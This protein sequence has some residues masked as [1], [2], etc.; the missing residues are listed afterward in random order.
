MTK[1]TNEKPERAHIACKSTKGVGC[2]PNFLVNFDNDQDAHNPINWRLRKKVYTS[3][4][5]SLTSLGSVWA[6][7]A[8]APANQSI[9]DEFHT[10][11]TVALLGTCLLLAGWAFGPLLWAPLSELYGRKWPVLVPFFI[12]AVMSFATGAAKD[13]QTILITRF[14]NGFFGSAPI[15]STGA[16]FVDLWTPTQRGMAIVGYTFCVCGVPVTGIFQA[17]VLALDLLFVEESY[18]PVLLTRKAQALRKSTGNWALHA[19]WEE[20]EIMVK[21][22][23]IKYGLRPLQMLAT[24][25]CLCI[26]IYTAFIYAIYYASLASFPIIFQQTRHWN[27]LTGS[28]PYLALLLGVIWGVL[29]NVLSQKYYD[30]ACK[31]N[32]FKAVPEARLPQMMIGSVV[33]AASLFII[34]CTSTP[35]IHWIAPV[36][37]VVLMG[38]GYYAVFT[39]AINYLVDTFPRWGASALAA[40]TVA[41]S[42]LAAALPLAIQ[43]M[44]A[45]L[46]NG[47]AYSVLGFFATLNILIPY[48]FYFFGPS[49]RSRGKYSSNVG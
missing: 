30:A 5:Y 8:Y 41:R 28:L 27:N 23:A 43:P 14:F 32:D 4:L 33:L 48:V 37:G 19:K 1:P 11:P 21:D 45:A 13:I 9:A 46:G 40:N 34:G 49:I 38:F 47:W 25:I 29:L 36:I 26:T 2:E 12:S 22:L 42:A 20:K 31:A 3:L 15:M 44:F 24:P 17:L 35:T 6:S 18:V 16:V 7:T 39:S 10:S